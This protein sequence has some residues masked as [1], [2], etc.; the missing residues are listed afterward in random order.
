MALAVDGADEG[1]LAQEALG[2]GNL[3]FHRELGE[4]LQL[5][6]EIVELRGNRGLRPIGAR[7]GH[8]E[9]RQHPEETKQLSIRHGKPSNNL[10]ACFKKRAAAS[11]PANRPLR[12]AWR[13]SC[14]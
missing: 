13:P 6:V 10:E 11:R 3:P 2:G 9:D 8:A 5:I 14:S 4:A 7:R 1:W 12:G